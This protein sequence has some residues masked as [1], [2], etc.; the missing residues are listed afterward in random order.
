MTQGKLSTCL[1]KQSVSA[2]RHTDYFQALDG[3]RG[4][5]AL[6]VALYHTLWL[7]HINQTEFMNNGP[8]IIDLFFALSGFLMFTL[9][10]NKITDRAS[11][12]EFMKRR[13]A[14]LYPLHLFMLLVFLGFA[15]L[16]IF[17]HKTGIAADEPGEILPF[18]PGAVEGWF[19][20]VT[21]LTLTHSLGLHN[22]LTFNPP[23]WTISVEFFTYFVF[24]AMMLWAKP[25]KGWHYGVIGGGVILI[26]GGLALIRPNMDITYGLGFL[27]CVA[28]F[29][30]GGI[31]AWAFARLRPKMSD[32]SYVKSSVIE[33]CA[34]IGSTCFVIYCG[35]KLQFFVAPVLFIFMLVFAFDKGIVSQFMSQRVFRYLA[36]ISYSVYMVHVIISIFFNIFAE[37]LMPGIVG[38]DWNATGLG[39]DL[40]MIPYLALVI[41]F[42]HF[43]QK[44]VE[45]PGGHFI[46]NWGRQKP[47]SASVA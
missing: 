14:R 7:S 40:L 36:K 39:G 18:Q 42:A 8:V 35:G 33:L 22:D 38:H 20:L 43:T 28:G 17:A 13:F 5:L 34:I 15:I 37:R 12:I 25:K 27:R 6:F 30:T 32:M 26:Y 24:V 23:S 16:R 44:Y 45:V 19:S 1:A 31:A 11:S 21:N 9:Y 2:H 10:V 41:G 4:L 3:F 47:S 46:Q 29:F